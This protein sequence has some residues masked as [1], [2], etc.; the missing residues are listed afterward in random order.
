MTKGPGVKATR[1]GKH[2][3]RD[4][5]TDAEGCSWIQID[6][7]YELASWYFPDTTDSEEEKCA[8]LAH[9]IANLLD[10]M[11]DGSGHDVASLAAR[12]F[13]DDAVSAQALATDIED[14]LKRRQ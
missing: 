1:I 6:G 9:A 4:E 10:R 14:L 2:D 11:P 3:R 8:T 13:P 12:M 5:R 7:P